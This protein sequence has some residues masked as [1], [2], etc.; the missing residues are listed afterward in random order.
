MADVNLST[1]ETLKLGA[2]EGVAAL[3]KATSTTLVEYLIANETIFPSG[4]DIAQTPGDGITMRE[5]SLT[6]NWLGLLSQNCV[7]TGLVIP[8]SS[9]S[10][11]LTMPSGTACLAG[12][13]LDIPATVLT[14]GPS[15]TSY[16]YLKVTR[17]AA[18][19][20][21]GAWYE[22]NTTGT[23]PADSTFLATA[24]TSVGAITST[25]N[26]RVDVIA[27]ATRIHGP[28][29]IGA[30]SAVSHEGLKII[31]GSTS[32]SGIHFYTNLVINAGVTVTVPAGGRRFILIARHSLVIAGSINAAGAGAG[33]TG[34]GTD[35]AGGG[36][37]RGEGSAAANA[38]GDVWVGIPLG[39]AGA[40]G[41]SGANGGGASQL[42]NVAASLAMTPFLVHGGGG[43]GNTTNAS[44]GAGGGSIVLI[45]PTIRLESGAVLTTS[46][47]N[48]G[49]AGSFQGPGGGG[50]AGNIY[51]I[52]NSYTDAGA[53]FTQTAG[54]GGVGGLAYVGGNGAAGVKQILIY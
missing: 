23:A 1:T 49:N 16:V 51:I 12:R 3:A 52:A 42:T 9:L 4:Y 46:G 18:L 6:D 7:L 27:A 17:D 34:V 47:G 15:T 20:V 50:G 5:R 45:A 11:S 2:T 32:L 24:I 41:A 38:G 30:G 40:A 54:V 14:F 13:Y 31:S 43:G 10:L 39:Y 8:A 44:G 29:S 21:T 22:V 26:T 33:T 48:G 25:K 53:T 36:G 28:S 19:A 35:Q 37:T